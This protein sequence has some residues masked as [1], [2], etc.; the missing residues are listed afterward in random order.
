MTSPAR[1]T[2]TPQRWHNQLS[3]LFVECFVL[4]ANDAGLSADPQSGALLHAYME[5]A[6]KDV[7][8]AV[9]AWLAAVGVIP[10]QSTNHKELRLRHLFVV[11]R[12]YRSGGY[13]RLFT[14]RRVGS[15]THKY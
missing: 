6:V 10:A 13:G 7:A 1:C 4:A 9:A 14:H 8:L 15:S 12:E 2:C 3:R 5:S 11:S